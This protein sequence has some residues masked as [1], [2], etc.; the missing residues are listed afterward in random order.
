VDVL[1][2]ERPDSGGDGVGDACAVCLSQPGSVTNGG[3]AFLPSIGRAVHIA[4]GGSDLG[5][6]AAESSAVDHTWPVAAAVM[7]GTAPRGGRLVRQLK[8]DSRATA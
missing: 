6:V 3:Y 1:S 5:S 4:I 7:A 2:F 8:T